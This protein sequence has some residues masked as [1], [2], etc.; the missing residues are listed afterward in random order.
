MAI[1]IDIE[2]NITGFRRRFIFWILPHITIRRKC[3]PLNAKKLLL[4]TY[5]DENLLIASKFLGPSLRMKCHEFQ[6][7]LQFLMFM[8]KNNNNLVQKLIV[9]MINYI[10]LFFTP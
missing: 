6:K 3:K 8:M 7:T 1:N 10:R 2:I 4:L 9:G 5:C